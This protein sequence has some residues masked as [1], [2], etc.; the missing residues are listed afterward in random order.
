MSLR[1]SGVIVLLVVMLCPTLGPAQVVSYEATSLPEDDGWEIFQLFCDPTIWTEDG[2]LFHDVQMCEDSDPPE[3]QVA[4]YHRSLAEFDGV[5]TFF[6]EWVVE[7]TADRSEI[8]V[9]GG[10]N[11]S[12]WSNGG[13]NYAFFI[14]RD[15]AKLNR[16]T[17]R[18]A[19]SRTKPT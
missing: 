8:P 19:R 11:I 4:A 12:A 15:Q 5:D 7:T 13:V 14:A 6:V 2:W 16:C 3:G 18:T 10:A 1:P 17:T 9:G